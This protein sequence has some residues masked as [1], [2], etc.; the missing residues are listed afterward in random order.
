MAETAAETAINPTMRILTVLLAVVAGVLSCAIYVTANST[1]RAQAEAALAESKSRAEE[2]R[3]AADDR[4]ESLERENADLRKQLELAKANLDQRA[5]KLVAA[6]QQA[7][8]IWRDLDAAL[9]QLAE[10]NQKY[11]DARIKK[12]ETLA[13]EAQPDAVKKD[14]TVTAAKAPAAEI[15]A[16]D[17]GNAKRG[18]KNGKNNNVVT[19]R[20]RGPVASLPRTSPSF[21]ELDTDHDGRL[22]L[23]EYKRG[24][25]DAVDVEKEFNSL[26]TNG[27][28]TL[29]IDEYKAGHPDPPV[30]RTKRPKRN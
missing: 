27:D 14:P 15:K 4:V 22:T 9:K 25:P 5:E 26:D 29:S 10:L 7:L 2:A 16:A 19:N 6:E 30:V 23:D 28:G 1:R 18:Q 3:Q 11:S 21:S 13:A 24:F 12:A 20:K 8:W 17:L